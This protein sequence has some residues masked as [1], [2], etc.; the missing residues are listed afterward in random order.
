ML[1]CSLTSIYLRAF[2]IFFCGWFHFIALC[3]EKMHSVISI[4]VYLLRADF[5]PS[6]WSILEN[7]PCVLK[8]NVYSADLGWSVLNISIKSIWSSVSFKAIVSLL[9]FCLDDPSI[10][11][12]GL[13]KSLLIVFLSVSL[14]MFVINWF[15]CLGSFKLGA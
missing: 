7:V 11:V 13:L 15:I 12:S 14:F 8:K 9:I 6:M 2:Q 4:F 3:S 10:A 1:G 5:W